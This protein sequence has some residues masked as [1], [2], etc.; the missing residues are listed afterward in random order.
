MAHDVEGGGASAFFTTAP[1]V[2]AARFYRYDP[3]YRLTSCEGRAHRALTGGPAQSSPVALADG[4]ATERF[5]QTYTYDP[6]NNL[7]RLRHSGG[8][9]TFTDRKRVVSGKSV[10][11]RVDL[12]G[13][14][15]IKKKKNEKIKKN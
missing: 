11:V 3:F 8:A 1:A 14:R 9:S 10:S 5:T 13:R 12:G 6:A 15:S 2:S 7:T 4:S